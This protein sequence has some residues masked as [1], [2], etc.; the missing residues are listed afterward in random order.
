MSDDELSKIIG[1][2]MSKSRVVIERGPG[3]QLRHR[4]V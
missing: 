1:K 3:R 2:P 4:G